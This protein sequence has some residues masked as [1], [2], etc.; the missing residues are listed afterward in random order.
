[1]ADGLLYFGA[2]EYVKENTDIANELIFGFWPTTASSK[3]CRTCRFLR[4]F[5][6]IGKM[7]VIL[8]TW[9]FFIPPNYSA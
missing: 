7:T 8:F 6:M 5:A 4:D 2:V 3:G 9:R 1:M